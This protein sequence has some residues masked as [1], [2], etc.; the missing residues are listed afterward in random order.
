M[1]LSKEY[2][3]KDVEDEIYKQWEDNG[4][5]N[6]EINPLKEPFVIMMPHQI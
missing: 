4:C 5:F 2:N 3:H 6:S 1:E